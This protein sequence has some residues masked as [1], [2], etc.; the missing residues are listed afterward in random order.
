MTMTLIETKTLGTA[1]ASI[2]FASIPSTFTDLV[3]FVSG[4]S[5]RAANGDGLLTRFNNDTSSVY[6]VRSL[7]GDGSSAI[8]I[9]GATNALSRAELPA[10]SATANTFSNMA[11]YIPNYT[12][13]ANKSVSIDSV[14]ENNQT[15]LEI[16]I[17]A[18]LWSNTSAITTITL[19]SETGNNFVAGSMV[20]LYGV[21]KGSSGGVTVS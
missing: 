18:G 3:F 16:M 13:S 5:S 4:R 19:T 21:L 9:T 8:S 6:S 14:M 20:S 7:R 12:S 2:E 11:F 1:A 10:A 15:N 17:T